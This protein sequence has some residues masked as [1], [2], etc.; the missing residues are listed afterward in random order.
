M[1]GQQVDPY[2]L[3]QSVAPLVEDDDQCQPPLDE[4][5]EDDAPNTA[6][7]MGHY[8]LPA[9]EY[10]HDLAHARN[11]AQLLGRLVHYAAH[12]GEWRLWDGDYWVPTSEYQMATLAATVLRQ[13]YA[14]RMTV[15]NGKETVKRLATLLTETC[16][17]ARIHGGLNFL[18]GIPGIETNATDWDAD[19][20][21]INLRNGLLDL[22][23]MTLKPHEPDQ[24]CEK[25]ANV[26]F[27]P[28]AGCPLWE[29]HLARFLPNANIRRQL[30][31]DLGRALVG[32]CLEETLPIWYG[33]GSNGKT[34]SARVLQSVLGSYAKRGAPNLLVQSKYE[35]HS[36]EVA[37]LV[38]SRLV[39][40]VETD[41]D[42]HLAE[43]LVK[44]LTGGDTKKARFM[45]QDFFEFP[46]TFDLLL[47]T[48]HKPNITGADNGIWRREK[49][50]PWEFHI[51][52]AEQRPQ[53]EVVTELLTEASGIFNWLLDGL[54]DWQANDHWVAPEVLAATEQYR[55][56]EDAL[57]EYLA[58]RCE[59]GARYVI[60]VADLYDDYSQWV[61][62]CG[63]DPLNKAVFGRLLRQR[64]VS[65]RRGGH[66]GP[67]RWV[68]V[69]L[70]S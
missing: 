10:E 58:E 1:V 52:D 65:Q 32:G 34:T 3:L 37:D 39:I 25:M 63:E 54:K 36:T 33:G 7:S 4:V 42:K 59:F 68:G 53:E 57:A 51:P 61:T 70:V 28:A 16:V 11:L 9:E 12:R 6:A 8:Q 43:A 20:W 5:D 47:I 23:S 18:R 31:R 41:A 27:V 17:Y 2:E 30:Q 26:V 14:Q 35:R 13:E 45:R 38:G 66:G 22:H 48:N 62:T 44:E 49:L 64:G 50:I 40:S 24:L 15:A 19:G 21:V 56:E 69:R 60:N 67:R 55:L 29:Q 46:Q